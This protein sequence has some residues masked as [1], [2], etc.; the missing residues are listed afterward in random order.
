MTHYNSERP[1]RNA[2]N[3]EEIMKTNTTV[4]TTLHVIRLNPT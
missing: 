2:L 3:E 4:Y 1:Y